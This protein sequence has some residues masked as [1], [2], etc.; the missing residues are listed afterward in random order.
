MSWCRSGDHVTIGR[1]DSVSSNT[2]P[3][4]KVA[5]RGDW[6]AALNAPAGDMN[7][8]GRVV[9]WEESV[10]IPTYEPA[11]PDRHPMYLDRRV[12]QGSS[13]AVYPLPVY[14]R[15]ATKPV[16]RRWRAIHL[17]NEFV[18]VMI[19]PEIGGRVH[20]FR[21]KTNGYDVI[22][23]QDVIKPALVGLAGPWVSGGIE[24][25][26]PQHHRPATF[27]PVETLIE[28][29]DDGSV[30]V[31]CSDHD[32]LER[33][34]AMHGVC[35]RPGRSFLEL[36]VRLYNRTPRVQTFLWWANVA[37]RVHELYQS[38]FPDDVRFV[39]DHARRATS[40]FPR[41][42]GSYYGVDYARRTQDGID[43]RQQPSQFV[44]PAGAY[45]PDD[46]S[47]YANIPVPTSY[48]AV[49]SKEDFFGGYDHAR[50][51]GIVH[52]ADH[53]VSPGKKQWTWGNHA[54]GYAWDRNLT[55]P[56]AS[57]VYAPYIELMAGV[58]TD[59]QPDF[60]YLMP[61][62]T[63]CFSQYWYPIREIGPAHAATTDAAI[64]VRSSTNV[65]RSF[66]IGVSVTGVFQRSTITLRSKRSHGG[67]WEVEQVWTSDLSPH[68]PWVCDSGRLSD[69]CVMLG[70]VIR[71]QT[72]RELARREMRCG[73]AEDHRAESIGRSERDLRPA[74]EPPDPT[75]VASADELYVIGVHL[76]QYRHATR[77]ARG[78]FEEAI[79]RDP[80]DAR[81]NVA[82]AEM[83][84]LRGEFDE[85]EKRLHVAIE[86][87]TSRNANPRDGEALYL[88]GQV[89]R[90]LGRDDDAYDMFAK[91]AWNQAYSAAACRAMGEIDLSRG[92]NVEA[93]NCFR[94]SLD[95]N[96]QDTSARGLLAV[97]LRRIGDADASEREL[98]EALRLDPLDK[99]CQFLADDG[100]DDSRW[101]IDNRV[102]LDVAFDVARAGLVDEAVSMLN[103]ADWDAT[104]G[105]VP[106]AAYAIAWLEERRGNRQASDRVRS[107]VRDES[108]R[109]CFPHGLDQL[110]M[111]EAAIGRDPSDAIAM[112]LLATQLYHLGRREEAIKHWSKSAELD[113]SDSGVWRN[114]GIASFNVR[115]DVDRARDALARASAIAPSDARI[116]FEEDQLWKRTGVAP[117]E[118]LRRIESRL[119]VVE[120]RDDLTIEW[121]SLL[122][123]V[124]R[125]DE[126]SRVMEGRRFQPWEGGEGLAI[127]QY[128]R[129]KLA[130]GREA[131]RRRDWKVAREAIEATVRLPESLGEARHPLSNTADIEFALGM[132]ARGEGNESQA[133][134]HF[135][136][137][138]ESRGDF[139]EMS[140]RAFS[141]LSVYA[142]L[143]MRAMG[144]S[145]DAE[146]LFRSILEEAVR[147]E[148]APAKVDYFATSLPT[149]LLFNDDL[150]LRQR[151][152]ALLM[153]GQA[154]LALGERSEAMLRLQKAIALD[155]SNGTV[156]DLLRDVNEGRCVLEP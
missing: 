116:L 112:K 56:D 18:R 124:G 62:E 131:M 13:G 153:Q 70:V 21:D 51:A 122:N 156:S 100:R 32:P 155:P 17:E 144:K 37:T 39:F 16:D 121:V 102:R 89:L 57:G 76:R 120:E 11:E 15:I 138:A 69:A 63:R 24:F 99:V 44:P 98:A 82:L 145:S 36:R 148:H 66:Q 101:A 111:L 33:M 92:R 6:R 50:R 48:M 49:G 54:F 78:Y 40:S 55:D 106:L 67:D 105:S 1:M 115:G 143:A 84:Y 47:W 53:R 91:A 139:Q 25:N 46:L 27:M 141:E 58:F 128:S 7:A 96:R 107:R 136:A 93:V 10:V 73:D 118:R 129:A 30:T 87:M 22:Y 137:A 20:L 110:Q 125:F 9:V 117:S 95:Q 134:A 23:R 35:L 59:N 132:I 72:G 149:M 28:R 65:E 2:P 103:R 97:A 64:S 68:V 147:L 77:D 31:W 90:R 130:I 52:V 83:A 42:R 135:R 119:N 14:S 74:T 75:D 29:G 34:K 80:A 104:D 88:A 142:G 114:L 8:D 140:V 5:Q 45:S 109:W 43:R 113:A 154:L 150:Q 71:D 126:A 4:Q 85:A 151:V 60:S 81:C 3:Q 123:Q 86:R 94:R 61:Y 41:C 12:Y 19:L 133:T 38:F 146:T 108:L 79:R 127:A 26:W 152:Q